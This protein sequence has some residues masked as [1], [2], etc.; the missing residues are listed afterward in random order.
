VSGAR[1]II[2]HSL[3]FLR[4]PASLIERGYREHGNAYTLRVGFRPLVVLA[5]PDYAKTVFD[6]TDE[7]LS[8]RG[9]LAF[10]GRLLGEDFYFLAEPGEYR[11]Q[12]EVVL[13]R[14]Q[15]R[16]LDGYLEVM[17]AEAARFVRRLGTQ[18]EFDL[19]N[20]LGPLV[21]RIAA[22]CFLGNG[23]GER[24]D[25]DFFDEFRRLTDGIDPVLPGWLPLPHLI[26]GRRSTRR[27]RAVVGQMIADRRAYPAD[28]PDF[29]QEFALARYGDGAPLPDHLRVKIVLGFIF[30]GYETTTGQLAWSLIDLL[31]HPAELAGVRAEQRE[32]L[33]GDGPLTLKTVNQLACLGR[34]LHESQRLHPVVLGM[35]RSVTKDTQ[36]GGYRLPA[37]SRAMLSTTVTHRLPDLFDN[38]DSYLPGR[39]VEVPK[40]AHQLIGFGG[41]AHRCLGM[42][43]AHLEMKVIIT[44][45]LRVFDLELADPDPRPVRGPR[46]L[47]PQSPCR[48]RYRLRTG[49]TEDVQGSF[50]L[51]SRATHA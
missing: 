9:G 39:Y 51:P 44:R 17:E 15:S 5:G 47:W 16:Q 6:Q 23:L 24:I 32:L 42:H 50:P 38:P 14:F 19:G 29:L 30:A 46:G 4:D 49:R 40:A 31:R 1:P 22:G 10:L 27:L 26:R 48:V 8:L 12:R 21:M 7:S 33:P 41:G 37:G 28:P 20:G 35:L 2:G 11:R 45:L 25:R 36:A 18:G 3:Q 34:A 43:F 13:P